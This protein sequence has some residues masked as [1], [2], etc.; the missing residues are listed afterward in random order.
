MFISPVSS[1]R[2]MNIVPAGG[3]RT[4]AVG[5]HSPDHHLGPVVD[6][7]QS[8][9]RHHPPLVEHLTHESGGMALG[10]DAGGPQIGHGLL[11]IAHARQRGGVDAGD[12]PFEAIRTGLSHRPCPP[13]RPAAVEGDPIGLG[14]A[15]ER[16]GGGQRLE[17]VELDGDT[18]FEV[19][20]VAVGPVPVAL[21][22]DVLGQL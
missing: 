17:H 20:H 3:G 5:D 11:A 8:G 10:R 1:S 2:L 9:R 13:Q 4:L 12:D 7:G 15:A 6:L 22:H 14:E 18:T 21:G 19:L 16:A